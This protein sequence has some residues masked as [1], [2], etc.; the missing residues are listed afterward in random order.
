M[1]PLSPFWINQN[2]LLSLAFWAP[3]GVPGFFFDFWNTWIG[4][5]WKGL[6]GIFSFFLKL[7]F[8]PWSDTIADAI[9][10][11]KSGGGFAIPFLAAELCWVVRRVGGKIVV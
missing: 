7:W 11:I 4:G 9:A 1:P 6:F 2:E 10:G 5:T 8:L 3:R